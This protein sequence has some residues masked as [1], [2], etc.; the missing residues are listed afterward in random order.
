VRCVPPLLLLTP[1]P[2]RM[3][4]LAAVIHVGQISEAHFTRPHHALGMA[5]ILGVAFQMV[6]GFCRPHAPKHEPES[7]ARRL[8]FGVHRVVAF[9]VLVGGAANILLGPGVFTNVFLGGAD[10]YIIAGSVYSGQNLVYFINV[11][12]AAALG[13]VCGGFLF[14]TFCRPKPQLA[15]GEEATAKVA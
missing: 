14:G 11:C 15:A 8:W 1:R 2:L 3:Q 5:V 7:E 4:R 6:N 9:F 12:G 10:F 13:A